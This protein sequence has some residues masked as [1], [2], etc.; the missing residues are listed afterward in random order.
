[1]SF[2]YKRKIKSQDFDIISAI[3]ELKNSKSV[4]GCNNSQ[5][6]FLLSLSL[7]HIAGFNNRIE[8]QNGFDYDVLK[9]PDE[10]KTVNDSFIIPSLVTL[11]KNKGS[12]YFNYKDIINIS[13]TD[14]ILDYLKNNNSEFYKF[15][16]PTNNE[17]EKLENL[18]KNR[19]EKEQDIY[20]DE[21]L[22]LYELVL[23]N[24]RAGLYYSQDTYQNE[25]T[26]RKIDKDK[27]F[28]ILNSFEKEK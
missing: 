8:I 15:I 12:N 3:N 17:I 22:S 21:F 9:L 14:K 1:M 7:S 25:Y 23:F 5:T 13:S 24:L 11:L 2:I 26:Y 20:Y 27:F 28:N 10:V 4:S 16:L 19:A 6:N 18:I